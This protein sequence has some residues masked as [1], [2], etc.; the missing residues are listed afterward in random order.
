MKTNNKKILIYLILNLMAIVIIFP[1]LWTIYVSF[2]KDAAQI[3]KFPFDFSK[4]GLQN[5]SY[6]FSKIQVSSWYLNSIIV[7]F[8]ITFAN[9]IVNTTAGYSLARLNFPGKNMIFIIIL[10]IML[11]PYQVTMIPIYILLT[12]LKLIN[13]YIGLIL[14]FAFNSFGMFLMRQFFL[15]VPKEL[16]DAAAIDGLSKYGIFT[17]VMVPLAKTSLVTQFIIIF[18]WNWN[19]FVWPSILVNKTSMYTLS[20][21]INTI[22]SQYFSMPTT[23]MSGVVILTLPVIVLFI[24]FQRYFMQGISTVGIK[25]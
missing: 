23:V 14:P 24:V 4:Y 13:S 18:M 20:V 3:E 6:L 21:G 7:A 19:S 25:G 11:V 8:G 1:F 22:K 10:G 9:L 15:T 17:K 2:L 12:D 16:E 5:F